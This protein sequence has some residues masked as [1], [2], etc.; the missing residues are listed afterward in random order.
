MSAALRTRRPARDHCG[1]RRTR[2]RSTHQGW[3]GRRPAPPRRGAAG[4][5]PARS[6]EVSRNGPRPS[7]KAECE[8][9]SAWW[10]TSSTTT[11]SV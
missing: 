4:A 11:V 3:V 7:P 2:S 1:F 10:P 6:I 8:P 9:S 5:R